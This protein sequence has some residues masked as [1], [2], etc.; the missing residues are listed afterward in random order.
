MTSQ[1]TR[2]DLLNSS[3]EICAVAGDEHWTLYNVMPQHMLRCSVAIK[4]L[5]CLAC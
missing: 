2:L 5:W 4:I 3:E 1:E